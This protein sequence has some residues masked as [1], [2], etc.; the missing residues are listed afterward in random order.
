MMEMLFVKC[1]SRL[2]EYFINI[3]SSNSSSYDTLNLNLF[4]K[5]TNRFLISATIVLIIDLTIIIKMTD[6]NFFSS[7]Q[8]WIDRQE[9]FIVIYLSFIFLT[10]VS[11]KFSYLSRI[12]FDGNT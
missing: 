2:N 3:V 1:Q 8:T 7:S 5:R 6:C 9:T 12:D 11:L 4:S 10:Y